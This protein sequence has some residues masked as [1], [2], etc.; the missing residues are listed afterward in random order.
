MNS[1]VTLIDD[2]PDLDQLEPSIY[3]NQMNNMIPV[4]E[5]ERVQKFIRNNKYDPHPVSGMNV[6]NEPKTG[7]LQE[8][9]YMMEQHQHQEQMPMLRDVSPP[10]ISCA[11]I[12]KHIENCPICGK[13]YN[14][15]KTIYIILIIFLTVVCIILLKKVLDV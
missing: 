11:D 14:N 1:K 12:Y 7:Y 5:M 2:L 3:N 13:L 6:Y 8:N 10:P 9:P 4:S 15:D